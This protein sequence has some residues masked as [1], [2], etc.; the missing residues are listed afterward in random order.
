[1]WI[2]EAQGRPPVLSACRSG[3]GRL[4]GYACGGAQITRCGA[5][6]GGHL[7]E[8]VADHIGGSV[9]R[10]VVITDHAA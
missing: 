3:V 4:R 6:P 2:A 7:R 8:Q 10:A 5:A 9:R 1:M